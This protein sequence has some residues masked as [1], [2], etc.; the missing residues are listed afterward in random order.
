MKLKYFPLTERANLGRLFGG[1]AVA[2]SKPVTFCLFMIPPLAYGYWVEAL[3]SD[4]HS[5]WA[6]T[7]VASILHFWYD[8]FIW[9]V[10][11]RQV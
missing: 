11:R 8:G 6:L 1:R 4:I 7:L 5:L 3:D 2:R 10:R 9:S